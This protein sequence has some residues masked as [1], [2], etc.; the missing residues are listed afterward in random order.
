MVAG[1]PGSIFGK[2]RSRNLRSDVEVVFVLVAGVDDA[3]N[4]G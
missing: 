4:R 1:A 3:P 2:Y